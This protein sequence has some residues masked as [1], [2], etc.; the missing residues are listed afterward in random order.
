MAQIKTIDLA[1]QEM[2]TPR[3][4]LEKRFS[5]ERVEHLIRLRDMYNFFHIRHR[6]AGRNRQKRHY[7]VFA[8]SIRLYDADDTGWRACYY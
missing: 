7:E 4:E 1:R 2:F 3:E 8:G 5:P 6:S